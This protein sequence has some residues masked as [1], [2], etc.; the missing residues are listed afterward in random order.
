[1][2]E[3]H[4]RRFVPHNPRDPTA[5][6]LSFRAPL[7]P[8]RRRIRDV[9]V[10][11]QQWTGF[12]VIVAAHQVEVRYELALRDVGISLRDF[13]VL[14]EI[15]QRRGLGQRALAEHVGVGD[16]RLSDQLS[17]LETEGLVERTLNETDLRRRRIYLT[18]EG[19]LALAAARER[20]DATDRAW[21]SGLGS[22][23]RPRFRALLERLLAEARP[24]WRGYKAVT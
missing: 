13:A 23:E 7:M 6:R 12:A 14:A 17:C 22:T 1:M 5:A 2:R 16:A 8:S 11:L 18:P 4:T 3:R 10:S 24:L 19:D 20:I 21:L 9:P 15:R